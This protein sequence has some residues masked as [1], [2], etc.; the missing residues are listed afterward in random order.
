MPL[1]DGKTCFKIKTH[2]SNFTE[3]YR[4]KACGFETGSGKSEAKYVFKP[5]SRCLNLAKH[6]FQIKQTNLTS[7]MPSCYTLIE[8]VFILYKLKYLRKY[9]WYQKYA[10]SQLKYSRSQNLHGQKDT[11]QNVIHGIEIHGAESAH[12]YIK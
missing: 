7:L 2:R 3:S 10:R 8:L 1:K 6:A 4:K 9:L 12:Q 5:K 11:E